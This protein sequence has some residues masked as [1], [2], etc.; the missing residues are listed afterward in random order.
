MLLVYIE[1]ERPEDLRKF[2]SPTISNEKLEPGILLMYVIVHFIIL[3]QN[4]VCVIEILGVPVS[5]YIPC[6]V[7]GVGYL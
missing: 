2:T 1:H 6:I 4:T 3:E 5:S 7:C